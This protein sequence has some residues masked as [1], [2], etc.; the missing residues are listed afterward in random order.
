MA[1][2]HPRSRG[3]YLPKALLSSAS[4]GS[5][6]LARGLRGR[7]VP[8]LRGPGGSSPLA[9]GLLDVVPPFRPRAWII[10]ARAGFTLRPRRGHRSDADHPRSRGVYEPCSP[11]CV[12]DLGS[13][14]LARGLR[15]HDFQRSG[16]L[17][18]HPRSRGVYEA[19]PRP[20]WLRQGSSPLAR[21]LHLPEPHPG[22]RQR[23]IPARAGFTPPTPI[24]STPP[25]DHPR[26]RGVYLVAGHNGTV[27]IGSSPLARGLRPLRAPHRLQMG[28]IPARA[29]FTGSAVSGPGRGWDHP[30][31]RGV[32][33]TRTSPPPPAAGSSPLARGLRPGVRGLSVALR[34]IPARAGFTGV[35]AGPP[36]RRRDHPRSRG[37]YGYG[38][39][40]RVGLRG[41]SPLA[42]GLRLTPLLTT[43]GSGIIPARAGFTS[44]TA[45]GCTSTPD[46][47]RSRGVYRARTRRHSGSG[48]S[49]PLARGL[50][51]RWLRIAT[52][53]RIIPARA[54]FTL[55]QAVEQ[56]RQGDHPRS[57]G[58]YSSPRTMTTPATGS[59]PLARGLHLRIVGIPTNP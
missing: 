21:G 36:R 33:T 24:R 5:S 46:H 38:H 34:I 26:S 1:R 56:V 14:P 25:G 57:R 52:A 42:R 41:S 8:G 11:G 53:V 45:G 22:R 30:R 20:S 58:V 9:R 10:P 29:G 54:G 18:D 27:A 55:N 16:A 15:S 2:D 35:G 23:I 37:V 48:G 7:L 47:P 51:M 40:A 17:G 59:S 39:H 6:P 19:D 12:Q 31:S 13:S 4:Q 44:R 32:Y 49:S 3:V 50:P 43:V 28:I